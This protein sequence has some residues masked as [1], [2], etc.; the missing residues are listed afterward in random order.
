M[1]CEQRHMWS[2]QRTKCVLP[3][4]HHHRCSFGGGISAPPRMLHPERFSR[5]NQVRESPPRWYYRSLRL[6]W[7]CS[8]RTK[9]GSDEAVRNLNI[10][11]AF[12][13]ESSVKEH[14]SPRR[15]ALAPGLC[16]ISECSA[17][18]TTPQALTWF[19]CLRNFLFRCLAFGHFLEVSTALAR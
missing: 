10:R 13:Q 5:Q 16:Q 8:P 1:Q 11:F 18:R 6:T 12:E 17:C 7:P 3:C 9:G 19:F 14:M 4:C 15:A 2:L